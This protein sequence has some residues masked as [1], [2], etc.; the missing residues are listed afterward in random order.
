MPDQSRLGP[1]VGS[2]VL[3]G[4]NAEKGRLT[5]DMIYPVARETEHSGPGGCRRRNVDYPERP[6]EARRNAGRLSGGNMDARSTIGRADPG[7]QGPGESGLGS[8]RSSSWLR[9]RYEGRK[10]R[11]DGHARCVRPGPSGTIDAE[12]NSWMSWMK[13]IAERVGTIQGVT[14]SIIQTK[15]PIESQPCS[16]DSV[17][18]DQDRDHG[19]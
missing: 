3:A 10:G 7:A 2:Y 5:Y 17:D 6:P 14:T 15:Q 18:T 11:G 4:P 13:S 9:A 12:W 8:Q 16:A 19:S 1:R